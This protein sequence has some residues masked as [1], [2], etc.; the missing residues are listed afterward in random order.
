MSVKTTHAEYRKFTPIWKMTRDAVEGHPAINAGGKTYLPA[1]FATSD[2]ERYAVYKE[3]A[4]FMGVTGQTQDATVGMV[5]RKPAMVELPPQLLALTD[6]IDGAGQSIDQLAKYSCKEG[7]DVGR[8]GFLADYPSTEEGLNKAQESA[9]GLRPYMN[10]Y[11]AESIINWK[12]D[13]IGGKTVLTLVVLK[14]Q[15]EDS[16]NDDE[17][18]HDLVDQYRV[19]RLRDGIY[20]QQ[21]YDDAGG[22]ITEE[23]APRMAGGK[24]FDYIP[25]FI[26]GASNNLPSCDMPMLYDIAL[27]N[28]AH[29]Q[30][31]ADHREN[32]FVHG[33]LTLGVSTQLNNDEFKAA[34]PKGIVVGA[35]KGVFLGEGGAFHSVTAPE[36]SSLRTGLDDLKTEMRDLG[37]RMV[38]YSG[39]NETAEAARINA[40]AQSSTLDTLVL[41]ISDAMTKCLE[42]MAEFMGVSGEIEYMLNRDFWE[43]SLNPQLITA[44]TGLQSTGTI[45]K[46]DT[47]YM[48]RQGKIGIEQ[49]RTDEDIDNDVANELLDQ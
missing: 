36:S 5:F 40:S 38:Q 11:T 44:I 6:N 16:D 45:A 29:Y 32:L 4:Y 26:A 37:A 8:I 39:Q 43:G 25:F 42:S 21:L 15:V 35:R 7:Q 49:G 19:L 20:T 31:T 18:T 22:A 23:Y 48:I 13:T 41:N 46:A 14:E 34:N 27:V 10:T 1:D 30:T 2:P 17:F 12:T 24:P 28:I 3:R 47:R 33:Q 9:L